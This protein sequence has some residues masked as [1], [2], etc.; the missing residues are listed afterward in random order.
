MVS[1]DVVRKWLELVCLKRKKSSVQLLF[2]I[3]IYASVVNIKEF[4]R[5]AECPDRLM[6]REFRKVISLMLGGY[7]YQP[8]SEVEGTH[9]RKGRHVR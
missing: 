5:D 3:N 8:T 4:G 2:F 9:A 1:Q 6:Y 7:K